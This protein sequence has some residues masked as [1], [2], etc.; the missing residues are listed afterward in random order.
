MHRW[1]ELWV[2]VNLAT[3]DRD[4]AD[5]GSAPYG[6]IEDAALAIKDGKIAWLGPGSALPG[7]AESLARTVRQG[8]GGWLTPGLIDCHTHI[9]FGG[10]RW[11]EFELRLE[12]ASYEAIARAGG[13]IVATV[14]ATRAASEQALTDS[15]LRRLARLVA[16]GVTTVEV[17][18]GYGLELEAELKMLRV[19]RRLESLLPVSVR[20]SFLGA[21]ALPTEFAGR[22]GDYV[23]LLCDQML[24]AVAA[25]GLA[26]AVDAF[27]EGIAFTAEET[28]RIFARATQ[29]GLPVK[30]HADQLSDTGGSGLAA[31]FGALSADHLEHASADS[32]AAMA[33]AGTVAVLLPGASY[34]LRETKL[35][36]VAA[37]REAGVPMA[38][39]TNCNPGS[40]PATSLLLMLSMACTLFRLTPEEA[41]AGITRN[42]AQ[43]L[44]LKDRGRLGVGLRADLVLWDVAHPAELAYWIGH[45]PR[46]ATIREGVLL[47]Q[48]R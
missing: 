22:Q 45:N 24:P 41:L 17:K 19:A 5:H 29:L 33:S 2:D 47:D 13:G 4:A 26:D 28:A 21:H 18:S 46:R 31:R 23:T 1:D 34:F 35:P 15:A 37:L 40:S 8:A 7:P 44:G 16:E 11:R 9:V 32:V 42:A 38:I 39:A 30:L 25:S 20:T 48:P 10:E 14:A 27:C 3:M 36:P 43:A 12:G 6:T